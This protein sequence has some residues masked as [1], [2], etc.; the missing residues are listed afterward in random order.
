MAE[1]AMRSSVVEILLSMFIAR[2]APV[3]NYLSV[4]ANLVFRHVSLVVF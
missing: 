4:W 3:V 2:E 1:L